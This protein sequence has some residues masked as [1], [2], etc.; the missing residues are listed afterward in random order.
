[1]SNKLGRNHPCHCGSEKKYKKCCLTKDER[2]AE[3]KRRIATVSRKDLI[4]GP[5]KKCSMC[6][7]NTFG[8]FIHTGGRG[9]LRECTTCGHK[10]EHSYPSIQKKIIYLDQFFISNI[11]KAL[12]PQAQSHIKVL[13]Q[14][15]WIDAYTKLD[16]LS[17]KNLTTCPDSSFHT[18]E[19]LLSGD[20]PYKMLK[21]VYEHLS[22]GCTFYDYNTITRF[23]VQQHLE[24]YIKGEPE[25]PLELDATT[26]I[27]G[28]PHEWRGGMGISINM[29]PYDGQLETIHQDR[30]AWYEGMKPVFERWQKEKGRDFM[31][32]FNEEVS[33][34]GK[35][36]IKAHV[37]FL[38]KRVSLSQKYADQ[39]LAGQEHDIDLNDIFPPPS[40][41]MIDDIIRI[42]K[43]RGVLD[44]QESYRK[45]AEYLQS[46]YIASIPTVHISSLLFAALARKAAN[47]QKTYP[48]I[49]TITDV[50]AIAS[51]LPYCDAMFV[52]NA[53]AA[54]LNEQPLKKDIERYG[55]KIFCLNTKEQF[56]AYLDE[57]E[58]T[59]SPEHLAVVAD[60]GGEVEPYMSLLINERQDE[61]DEDIL[62][63]K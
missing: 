16:I 39:T 22:H 37:A 12:D 31:D 13:E 28:D 1:M 19:S 18:D 24:N 46:K 62:E 52:D 9:Y 26:V 10:E 55:T 2:R 45:I 41:Q 23:Q 32:W 61:E 51:L 38:E 43:G 5:Y 27:H 6:R 20:P 54:L 48:N 3:L 58:S 29:R 7:E 49:G 25:K 50:N 4:S 34:F 8:V 14:P 11:A 17:K 59:A 33:A 44:V 36:T 47:G 42:M 57:I 30:K 15:F 53:M 21:R 35:A 63:S 60:S 56:L 40:S